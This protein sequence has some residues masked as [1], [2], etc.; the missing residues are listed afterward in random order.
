MSA[1]FRLVV[2]V[3]GKGSNLRAIYRAI[4]MNTLDAK[5]VAVF[6][7]RNCPG[8]EWAESAQIPVRSIRNSDPELAEKVA[9]FKPDLIV[10]AGYMRILKSDFV[11]AYRNRI[12]NIHP[13]LLP[14]FRGKDAVEQALTAGVMWT[15]C[16]V[17][18]VDEGVDTGEILY[19]NVVE[20]KPDDTAETLHARIQ[21]E[22]HELLPK[23]IQILS[24]KKTK[25]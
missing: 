14:A 20:I 12:I 2:F 13:S 5:I 25:S 18:F 4:Q 1:K 10:L 3:S 6:S 17:H 23:V 11:Q 9:V 8:L 21:K 19:Q 15:G 24:Q 22:E 7:D 16:T